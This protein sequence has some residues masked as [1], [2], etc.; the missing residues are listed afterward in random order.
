MTTAVNGVLCECPGVTKSRTEPCDEHGR[1]EQHR[2]WTR[3][4]SHVKRSECGV[5]F[6]QSFKHY[7]LS[8]N[9]YYY[10]YS[11][12]ERP[13]NDYE[14]EEQYN[15]YKKSNYKHNYKNIIVTR[16]III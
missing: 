8:A 2:R 12:H 5:K 7:L 16:R 14:Q 10:R 15:C 4:N 1:N 6:N 3:L 13:G 11:K 9:Y